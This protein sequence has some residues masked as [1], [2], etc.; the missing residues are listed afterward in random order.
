MIKHKSCTSSQRQED[1]FKFKKVDCKKL[2]YKDTITVM[3]N[4]QGSILHTKQGVHE[5]SACRHNTNTQ[6]TQGIYVK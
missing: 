1:K 3:A 2:K 6:D 4:T 5:H